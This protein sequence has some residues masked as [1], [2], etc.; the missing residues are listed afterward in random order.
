MASISAAV[1]IEIVMAADYP[2]GPPAVQAR[3]SRILATCGR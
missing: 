2:I 1:L 3:R